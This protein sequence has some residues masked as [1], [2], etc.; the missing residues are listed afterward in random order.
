MATLEEEIKEKVRSL[1]KEELEKKFINLYVTHQN[2]I[3][4]NKAITDD[5]LKINSMYRIKTKDLDFS[6]TDTR[7]RQ[8]YLHK[9]YTGNSKILNG[10]LRILIDTKDYNLQK[11]MNAL[12]AEL[13][14]KASEKEDFWNKKKKWKE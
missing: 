10:I 4:K 14:E 11:Y 13:E 2:L 3:K 8:Q 7:R 9:E 6:H 5:Y 12:E 1:S